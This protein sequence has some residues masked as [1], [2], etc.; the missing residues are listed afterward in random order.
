MSINRWPTSISGDT[1]VGDGRQVT[2]CMWAGRE[3]V[4][5]HTLDWAVTHATA[6]SGRSIT[7]GTARARSVA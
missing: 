5:D 1:V 6:A 3:D 4:A 2:L 7:S